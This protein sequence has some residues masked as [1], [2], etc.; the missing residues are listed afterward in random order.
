MKLRI[1]TVIA[2]SALLTFPAAAQRRNDPL[3]G[4][5][6]DQLREAAQDPPQRIK[7]LLKFTRARMEAVEQMRSNPKLADA[8]REKLAQALEDFTDLVDELDDNLSNYDKL[9]KDLRKP[10]HDVITADTEFQIKLKAMKDSLGNQVNTDYALALEAAID[11]VNSSA[12][13]SRAL[14]ADQI[15]KK[16]QEKVAEKEREKKNKT[17]GVN[18]AAPDIDASSSG[19]PSHGQPSPRTPPMSEKP[20]F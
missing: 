11:S 20:P 3:T 8:D 7:L 9:S 16:G 10:L 15:A 19:P 14:L 13:S 4:K 18:P 5:E 17:A 12:D 2:V 6:I 1:A